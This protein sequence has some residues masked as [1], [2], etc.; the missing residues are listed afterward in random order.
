MK[1]ILI[2]ILILM[3]AAC[4]FQSIIIYNLKNKYINCSELL[5]NKITENQEAKEDKLMLIDSYSKC[6][7]NSGKILNNIQVENK[8]RK[9][10]SLKSLFHSKIKTIYYFD[11]FS[12]FACVDDELSRFNNLVK[13]IGS[14]NALILANFS[15][16]KDFYQFV[17][18]ND[19][20]CQICNTNGNKLGINA[21]GESAIIVVDQGLTIK[22]CFIPIKKLNNISEKYYKSISFDYY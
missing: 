11:E 12:C 19:I 1:K 16:Y 17:C 13:K 4:I 15:S 8:Q 9:K 20:I 10:V 5:K 18:R 6:F 22:R 3:G 14:E 7:N 21:Q 2:F